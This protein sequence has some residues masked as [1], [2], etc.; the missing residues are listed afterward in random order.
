MMKT[1]ENS[2]YQCLPKAAW[3][4]GVSSVFMIAALADPQCRSVIKNVKSPPD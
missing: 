4:F 3:F 1:R 2:Q